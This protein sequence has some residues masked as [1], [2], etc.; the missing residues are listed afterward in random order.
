MS[1]AL[2]VRGVDQLELI[3]RREARDPPISPDGRWLASAF[4]GQDIGTS[5]AIWGYWRDP[6]LTSRRLRSNA[7]AWLTELQDAPYAAIVVPRAWHRD[8]ETASFAC[9]T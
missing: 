3:L 7:P 9:R 2:P 1:Q 5:F 6:R 4:F 8:F